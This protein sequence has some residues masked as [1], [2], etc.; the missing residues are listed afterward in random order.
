MSSSKTT[1]TFGAPLG[2]FTSK[3]G[4]ALALRASS[5][6]IV[7]GEGS[8]TGSTVRLICCAVNDSGSKLDAATSKCIAREF[9]VAISDFIVDWIGL[10][11]FTYSLKL[12]NTGSVHPQCRCGALVRKN[13]EVGRAASAA[14]FPHFNNPSSSFI[15]DLTNHCDFGY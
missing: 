4:G 15:N 13:V 10:F 9:F 3:R 7:G 8:G 14:L 11:S 2:A 12:S 1:T 5:S 6:V